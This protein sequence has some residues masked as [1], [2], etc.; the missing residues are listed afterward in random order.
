VW[1]Y[2]L[3]NLNLIKELLSH[4][5][6]RKGKKKFSVSKIY[7][8]PQKKNSLKIRPFLTLFIDCVKRRRD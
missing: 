7:P 1:F 2:P 3:K 6:K 4:D 8:I 5:Y